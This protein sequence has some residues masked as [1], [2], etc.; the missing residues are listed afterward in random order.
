MGSGICVDRACAIGGIETRGQRLAPTEK[1]KDMMKSA[2]IFGGAVVVALATGGYVGIADAAG[3]VTA[4]SFCA[5]LSTDASEDC[6]PTDHGAGEAWNI[7]AAKWRQPPGP[8]S[9]P[10]VALWAN[11]SAPLDDL[12]LNRDHAFTAFRAHVDEAMTFVKGKNAESY[13]A[14][15]QKQKAVLDRI[16]AR[17]DELSKEK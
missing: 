6:V 13:L 14:S 5:Q 11:P 8:Q 10:L 17:K 16:T 7:A 1:Q 3:S 15:M 12:A 2:H 4:D 9:A